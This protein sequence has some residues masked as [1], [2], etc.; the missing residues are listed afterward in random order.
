MEGKNDGKYMFIVGSVLRNVPDLG[1]YFQCPYR[2]SAILQTER[3]HAAKSFNVKMP[4]YRHKESNNTTYL[5]FHLI[6]ENI[7]ATGATNGAVVIWDLNRS[8]RSKQGEKLILHRIRI[9]GNMSPSYILYL[10]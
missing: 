10:S 1:V 5:P 6:S 2:K 7:I 3:H 8:T 9:L 4:L